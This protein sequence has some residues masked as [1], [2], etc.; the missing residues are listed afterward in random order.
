M[1]IES[2]SV[3]VKNRDKVFFPVEKITKGN[4]IDYY[5]KI[6]DLFLPF[7]KN[8]PLSLNRFPDGITAEGFY[9][10]QVP[11]YFPDWM[12]TVEIE[13]KEGGTNTQIVCNNTATLIYLANQGTVSFHPWLSTTYDL[14]KPD[15]LVFDLDPPQGDF[16]IVIKGAKNLRTLLDEKL[17]LNAFLMTTGSK[18]L[19]VV[20]P[21]KPE[22]K[23]E[24][25]RDFAKQAANFLAEK[26][27]DT[28]TVETR[29]DQ[30]KGRLF[31]DYLRNAYAQTSI[32]P[33]SVRAR[34]GAPVATPLG[35]DEL[36][37]DGLH[38]QTYTIKNIFR[39]LSHKDDPWN[40][41]NE[42]ATKLENSV[43]KLRK[44]VEDTQ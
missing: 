10:K 19:H 17:G 43:E 24:Y 22:N 31:I 38:S 9:Q 26:D 28:F 21:I 42:K 23:F 33:Y 29:K 4:L 20:C 37:K 6:A 34:E 25:V 32:P 36:D 35:W 2:P 3:E 13:K 16:E 11:D 27:P 5:E 44:V 40:S 8:R 41:F 7:L 39:R 15:K 14:Q 1:K 30:R 18:G 12:D